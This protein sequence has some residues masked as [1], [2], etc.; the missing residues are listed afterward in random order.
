MDPRP[1][2][3]GS[4]VRGRRRRRS[5]RNDCRPPGRR[6]V[7]RR[8]TGSGLQGLS[9]H[10]PALPGRAHRAPRQRP[11]GLRRD[12]VPPPHVVVGSVQ[13]CGDPRSVIWVPTLARHDRSWCPGSLICTTIQA[14]W[15]QLVSDATRSGASRRILRAIW[16]VDPLTDARSLS[17][18]ESL[19][20]TPRPLWCLLANAD[21]GDRAGPP[22]ES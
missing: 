22:A 12:R 5:Q 20:R 14:I 7:S 2:P 15:G 4:A 18:L 17:T 10:L 16:W 8:G 9:H 11:G 13:R 1:Q 19:R 21:G 6:E 3:P